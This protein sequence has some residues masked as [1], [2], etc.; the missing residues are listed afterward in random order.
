[1]IAPKGD[2]TVL[3]SESCCSRG[4][5][6]KYSKDIDDHRH[7]DKLAV[8]KMISDNRYNGM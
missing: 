6:V 8:H 1:M 7:E 2:H 4:A 3:S 5:H